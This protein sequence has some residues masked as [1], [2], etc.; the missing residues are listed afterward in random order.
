IAL[1]WGFA[2]RA[3]LLIEHGVDIN[4]PDN[5]SYPTFT[6][7]FTPYQSALMRGLPE[8]ADLI[9]AKGGDARPLPER[10]QFYAACMSGDEETAQR[11]KPD[12]M[13][14]SLETEAELLR[15][16]AGNGQLEAVRTMVALGFELSPTGGQTPLHAAAWRGQTEAIKLLLAAGADAKLRDPEHHS[17]PLGHAFYAQQQAVI[18]ILKEAEMDIFTA[19]SVGNTSQ[20]EARLADDPKWLNARFEDVLQPCS[21]PC[22]STWVTPIWRAAMS[23]QWNAVKHLLERGA[24]TSQRD[25]NGRALMDL[26][27]ASGQIQLIEL[28]TV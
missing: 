24:D 28:L 17:P 11:L 15:E 27:K 12:H 19:A 23:D 16:A 8:I 14:H 21:A 18:E 2:E 9:K 26:A 1:R 3:R 20:I 13:G 7:G 10:A 25:P 4:T 5:N 22:D 6:E